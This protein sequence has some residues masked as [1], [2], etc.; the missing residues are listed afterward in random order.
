[1]KSVE[2][3]FYS[4]G[5]LDE[6]SRMA[7]W[8]HCIDPRVKII[9]TCAFIVAVTSYHRYAIAP[10]LPFAAFPI[11]LSAG[12]DLPA[13]YLLGRL[14][15][16]SPFAVLV[17][18]FNPVFDREIFLVAGGIEISGGWISF[19]SI[20]L[21]FVLCVSAAI[22]LIATTGFY[23]I[24]DALR[25]LK[26]PAV[27]TNQL[28]LLYRYLYLLTEE[29]VRLVRARKLRTFGKKGEGVR[30]TSAL[31]ASFLSRTIIRANRIHE[32]MRARGHNF[33]RIGNELGPITHK[34]VVLLAV[35][36]PALVLLR[37]IDVS[38]II[39]SLVIGGPG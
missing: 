7:S 18:V 17:A 34:D 28:M 37:L 1:M 30:S 10:L 15:I 14:L 2:E 21:R 32:A 13:R 9:L 6:L 39:G 22:I 36:L 35:T 12:A 24:C 20:L 29:I 25:T 38:G 3:R 27:L 4:L 33:T 26:V 31:I 16:V 5:K 19:L 23:K 11:L 8:V